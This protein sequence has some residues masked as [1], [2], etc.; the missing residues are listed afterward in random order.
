[1][2]FHGFSWVSHGF[3]MDF[4]CFFH[5]FAAGIF[6]QLPKVE[7][8]FRDDLQARVHGDFSK[9]Q[10]GSDGFSHHNLNNHEDFIII[11][12]ICCYLSSILIVSYN[13]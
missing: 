6:L 13:L 7:T 4:P 1:M 11:N 3:P 5:A 2:V 10:G 8:F 9:N 12:N